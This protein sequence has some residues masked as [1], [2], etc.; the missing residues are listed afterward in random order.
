MKG[1]RGP[2]RP[3]PTADCGHSFEDQCN[4]ACVRARRRR[5][6][7]NRSGRQQADA[8]REAEDHIDPAWV[9]RLHSRTRAPRKPLRAVDAIASVYPLIA[10]H[11]SQLKATGQTAEFERWLAVCQ[12]LAGAT[13]AP[14]GMAVR[15]LTRRAEWKA[16]RERD[17]ADKRRV[18]R[19]TEQEE[20][21]GFTKLDYATWKGYI[22][23]RSADILDAA[24]KQPPG[25]RV[26]A[27]EDEVAGDAASTILRASQ[28]VDWLTDQKYFD[29]P[30]LHAA[31]CCDYA[32][33][34][35]FIRAVARQLD[36]MGG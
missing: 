14:S 36:K 16:E 20:P 5:R 11:A 23:G 3:A 28:L 33:R 4:A 10:G 30:L 1:T 18:T 27:Q 19:K 26:S 12:T 13:D 22:G 29:E 21:A 8:R 9:S 24:E 31:V 34:Q 6:L 2:R 35:Q 32:G 17:E 25:W 7:L 15:A